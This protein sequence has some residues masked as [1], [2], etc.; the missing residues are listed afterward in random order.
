MDGSASAQTPGHYWH[1]FN[2]PG[3]LPLGAVAGQLV[4]SVEAF[5]NLTHQVQ[6]RDALTFSEANTLSSDSANDS[7][8]AQLWLLNQHF[9]EDKSIPLKFHL[10]TIEAYDGGSDSMEHVTTFWAQMAQSDTSDALM[11]RAFPTTL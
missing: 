3:L 1:L 10:P 5:L 11:Y 6:A 2:D 9:N 7:F 4:F 8:Q